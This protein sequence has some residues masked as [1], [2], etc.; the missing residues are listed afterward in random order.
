MTGSYKDTLRFFI[1]GTVVEGDTVF[2]SFYYRSADT[3]GSEWRQVVTF[4]GDSGSFVRVRDIGV[5]SNPYDIA[6]GDIDGD[7]GI[8][9]GVANWGSGTV[10]LSHGCQGLICLGL[11]GMFMLG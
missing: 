6:F 5:G 8:D 4:S 9:V 1:T 2:V 7:G 3:L 10:V 11:I